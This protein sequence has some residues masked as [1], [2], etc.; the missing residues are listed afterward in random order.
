MAPAGTPPV[1]GT[2]A[3]RAASSEPKGT[4]A[5]ADVPTD[6]HEQSA[7]EG[8]CVDEAPRV[9]V[10]ACDDEEP[11]VVA[12]AP[13]ETARPSATASLRPSAEPRATRPISD[14]GYW[15]QVGAFRTDEA[16]IKVVSALGDEPVSLLRMPGAPLLRVLVGPFANRDAAASKLREI[17]ARGL[18]GFV[19]EFAR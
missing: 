1:A 16:A 6:S 2:S 11:P 12:P 7:V 13:A 8:A 18:D 14:L 5:P 10:A 3:D 4:R 17:K 9:V 19:A 15:V